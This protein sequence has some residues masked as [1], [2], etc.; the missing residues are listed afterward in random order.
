MNLG[1]L[2]QME[3]KEMRLSQEELAIK[4]QRS[5][6]WVSLIERNK[7][8]PLQEDLENLARELRSKILQDIADGRAFKEF[9]RKL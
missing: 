6:D 9:R 1:T 5:Q 8:E 2:I 3:R 4:I 7:Q